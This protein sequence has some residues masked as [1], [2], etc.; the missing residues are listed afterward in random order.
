L[1]LRLRP[2]PLNHVSNGVCVRLLSKAVKWLRRPTVR[3]RAYARRAVQPTALNSAGARAT[4]G[5]AG[6]WE[7]LEGT[8]SHVG[9]DQA[10]S[11]KIARGGTRGG[12][13]SAQ[14]IARKFEDPLRMRDRADPPAAAIDP[15]GRE[16]Q[17]GRPFGG[18]LD[19][20]ASR[21]ALPS[22]QRNHIKSQAGVQIVL[23]NAGCASAFPN[24][25]RP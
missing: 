25:R 20:V 22:S 19:A 7:K 13:I 4:S 21:R 15:L 14:S 12:A 23:K 3:E 10:T 17:P 18:E 24:T 16:Y 11:R 5:F 1:D 8:T 9:A 6:A 2:L